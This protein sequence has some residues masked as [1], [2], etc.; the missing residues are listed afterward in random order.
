MNIGIYIHSDSVIHKIPA[1]VKLAATAIAGIFIFATNDLIIL[2]SILFAVILAFFAAK[3]PVINIWK[4]LRPA[5]IMG[6]VLL[7]FHLICS[8]DYITGCAVALRVAS[9]IAFATLI[10]LT[11]KAS[12]MIAAFEKF[13]T[14]I[15]K[16]LRLIGIKI[17]AETISFMLSITI[18]FIPVLF[19]IL[20]EVMEAQ[21]ARGCSIRSIT[22]IKATI[23]PLMIR[24]LR[25]ADELSDAIEARG[26]NC[27]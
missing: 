23:I 13:I 21:K 26:Y 6:L 10:T 5:L 24:T 19:H 25:S 17:N 4:Q 18:R 27:K 7:G 22:G 16:P 20:R 14:F 9:L 15:S 2:P 11:T 8:D 1:S 12:E 3:I